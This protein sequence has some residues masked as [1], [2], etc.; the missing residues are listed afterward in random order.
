MKPNQE[1]PLFLCK[2]SVDEVCIFKNQVNILRYEPDYNDLTL[3]VLCEMLR[4][5][6]KNKETVAGM[7]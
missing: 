3:V 6:H 1:V 2:V 4:I 5:D 7:F